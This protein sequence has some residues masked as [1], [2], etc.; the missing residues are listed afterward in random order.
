M[1]L[2]DNLEA[3]CNICSVCPAGSYVSV[4]CT[5]TTDTLCQSCDHVVD[6]EIYR[7]ICKGQKVPQ[8]DLSLGSG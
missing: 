2:E 8:L 3:E 1:S 5:T 6:T 4:Q 7:S